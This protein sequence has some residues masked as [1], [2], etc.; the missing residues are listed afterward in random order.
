MF[1]AL[2]TLTD[3]L[4]GR[5][6]Q[7][8]QVVHQ[9]EVQCV[10]EEARVV[11]VVEGRPEVAGASVTEVAEAVVE[12][13]EEAAA[14]VLEEAEEE[15]GTQILLHAEVFKGVDH[16]MRIWSRGASV[17][18]RNT[19]VLCGQK[20]YSCSRQIVCLKMLSHH[21][22]FTSTRIKAHLSQ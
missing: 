5:Q 17:L 20:S 16:S 13:V 14:L 3:L 4:Q 19:M 21:S 10:E 8:E 22:Q 11:V 15:V 6:S 1:I 18:L 12:V 7:S 9:E 2:S